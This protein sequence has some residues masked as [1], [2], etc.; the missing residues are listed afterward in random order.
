[1]YFLQF[2]RFIVFLVEQLN[3]NLGKFKIFRIK[4]SLQNKKKH[5]F[6]LNFLRLVEIK[7][8]SFN[9]MEIVR[10]T[11]INLGQIPLITIPLVISTKVSNFTD[12]QMDNLKEENDDLIVRR[13]FTID[14]C[15]KNNYEHSLNLHLEFER[16]DGFVFSG[17]KEVGFFLLI[18]LKENI[19]LYKKIKLKNLS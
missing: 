11:K 16:S 17:P 1:M 14:F 10:N 8:F 19:N 5:Y 2:C 12:Q 18:I 7:I 9:S 13:P 6:K 4:T 15:L 3:L